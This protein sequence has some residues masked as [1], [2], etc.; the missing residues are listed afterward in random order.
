MA[1][2][3][4]TDIR[5][6]YGS[7]EVLRGI[8]LA[9]EDGEFMSLVG[10]SGCGKSTL[11][12]I[13]S[14]LES[15]DSGQVA[16]DGRDVGGGT[17]KERGVAM[18]FQDYA[19]YPHM[20]VAQNMAMPLI[21]ARLPMYARLPGARW[22]TPN[23]RSTRSGIAA[24]VERVAAQLRIGHL[25]DRRPA[26]LSGGQRQRVALG[27]ALVRDPSLF[28]MDEPL[29]NLDAKLRVEVRREIVELHRASGLTFVYVTHDQ[30]E[31]MTMSDRVALLREGRL[32]QVAAPGA[33][34]ANPASVE[35]ARFVGTPEINLLPA[36]AEP[37]GLRIGDALARCE[38]SLSE[39]TELIVG[40]RPEAL[41]PVGVSSLQ[42]IGAG[43]PKLKL[44]LSLDS[45]EDLGAEVV[46]HARVSAFPDLLVRL[47]TQ[48][49][50]GLAG[51]VLVPDRL[52]AVAPV[53]ALLL[54]DANGQRL[55][56]ARVTEMADIR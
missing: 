25:L 24:Q 51:P 54:F 5:K 49:A 19:L 21:M 23:H 34:Y 6:S 30:T 35:V 10:A 14:G 40:L 22:L 33:L 36:R 18:V 17:P 7:T 3:T 1:R 43:G 31:A 55:G 48:K 32:L 37:G 26:H 44:D 28:L 27:R 8:D 2:L 46:I 52:A 39:G 12:R 13:I 15:P 41:G 50:L 9:V 29:S 53:S 38:H 11:L 47:R 4:L 42:P 20:S 16:I 45:V 56:D